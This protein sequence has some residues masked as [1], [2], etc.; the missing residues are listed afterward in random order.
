MTKRNGRLRNAMPLIKSTTPFYPLCPQ[1]AY[2]D[3][4]ASLSYAPVLM[5]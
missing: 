2:S 4:T 1:L 5:N 3:L